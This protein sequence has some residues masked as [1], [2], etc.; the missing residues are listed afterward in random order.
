MTIRRVAK[1]LFSIRLN[2]LRKLINNASLTHL[3]D[4]N[5]F[6]AF[7]DTAKFI[8]KPLTTLTLPALL[9]GASVCFAQT[10]IC[11]ENK[12]CNNY[13]VCDEHYATFTWLQFETWLKDKTSHDGFYILYTSSTTVKIMYEDNCKLKEICYDT[14]GVCIP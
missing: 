5:L 7:F 3:T 14:K 9:I 1:L 10:P 11:E 12:Y 13:V 6:S 4:R 2:R 8:Y